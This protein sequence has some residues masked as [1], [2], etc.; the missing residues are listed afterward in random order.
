MLKPI[1]NGFYRD[2]VAGKVEGCDKDTLL[3]VN[4]LAEDRRI[5]DSYLYTRFLEYAEPHLPKE[6]TS[7]LTSLK[8][9]TDLRF[10]H[11]WY[12]EAR[13]MQR[14]IH[15]HVGPTNSGKTY[16][17]L[18]RLT[19]AKS[20]IYCGPLRLLAH[21]IF[22][23][24]NNNGIACNLVTGE[25]K[26]IISEDATLTSS[27]VEMVE[28][29]RDLEVAVVDEIQ[30]MGDRTRGWAWTQALLGLRAQEIHLCG[31]ESVVPLIKQ[32]CEA[33]DDEVTVHR[34]KRLTPLSISEKSLGGNYENVKKGDCVVTFAR[35]DIFEVKRAIERETGLRCAVV[36]GALPPESRALQAKAFNDAASNFDVL[37]ASDAV[38]MGL[39]LNI[40]RIVFESVQKY[41][42]KS[43]TFIH[44]PH[45]KQIA[46]RAGRFGTTYAQGEVTTFEQDDLSYVFE[47]MDT[48]TLFL[49][50][51]GIHPTLDI[52]EMFSAQMPDAPF[53]SVLQTFED[54][55]TVSGKYFLCNYGDSKALAQSMDHL[56]MSVRDRY[57]FVSAPTPL[58]D[59]ACLQAII[60]MATLYSEN[61]DID[62]KKLVK[63]PAAKESVT[64]TK[65]D[66]L[67]SCHKIIMI[68]K[69]LR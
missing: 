62:L 18:K 51:A 64:K 25:E 46:G 44:P 39:N 5:L 32:I 58:R 67:E 37:V 57:Q 11:E 21:E 55:A 30:M 69:W 38:G 50:T 53:S 43:F 10:P 47:A 42:G 2:L 40:K 65:L 60:E 49:K 16:S 41:D 68:Y 35:K 63:L 28:L 27:T 33:I 29:N 13:R 4:G 45:L 22:E 8:K 61:K 48:P 20:G 36:Y 6:I 9:I 26:R 15:L 3:S 24:M 66:Q 1:A 14:K 23:R 12:P 52:I 59:T 17:A 54:M 34:Y 7:K 31:E 19:E 56:D